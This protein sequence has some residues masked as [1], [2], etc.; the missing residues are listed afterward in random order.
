MLELVLVAV[1]YAAYEASRFLVQGRQAMAVANAREVLRLERGVGIGFERAFN[2]AVS[3]HRVLALSA[4]YLYATTHYV[5]T[6]LVLIWLWRRHNAAYRSARTALV[7][8]T[9]LGLVGFALLPVAPPRML[10]GFVDTM[11]QYSAAG[12]W[13][14]DASAPRGTGHLTNEFAAMPSLHV[15]WALWCGWQLLRHAKRPV[16]RFLGVAYPIVT[17][18]VVVG[19][20]NH[21]VLDV[22]AG[23]AV[24]LISAAAV[25]IA[26]NGFHHRHPVGRDAGRADVQQVARPRR[27][28]DGP[29][30]HILNPVTKPRDISLIEQ[31]VPDRDTVGAQRVGEQQLL[32]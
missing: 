14:M 8:A 32:E 11:A 27:P 23:V 2:L 9:V 22:L 10:P 28:V 19:T 5:V 29:G 26:S 16:V 1:V 13:G 31:R 12:W 4:D 15:G 24:I 21:Y 20:G 7:V 17:A 30:H 25:L 6:P 18:L 3:A